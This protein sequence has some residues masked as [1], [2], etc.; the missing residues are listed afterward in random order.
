MGDLRSVASGTMSRD[1]KTVF[2][3]S[4]I[5]HASVER[6]DREGLI[7]E[8]DGEPGE[9]R[10]QLATRAR[11]I[12]DRAAEAGL[13]VGMSVTTAVIDGDIVGFSADHAGQA[14]AVVRGRDGQRELV[15]IKDM[16]A[17]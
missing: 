17:S 14:C 2:T 12:L 5:L 10:S 16:V 4:R 7:A 6:L 11:V 1:L 13:A 8:V 3:H 9:T 15:Q